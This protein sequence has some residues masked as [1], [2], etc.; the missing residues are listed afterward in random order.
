MNFPRESKHFNLVFHLFQ[1]HL[2][3][4]L[5]TA[6]ELR[7]KGLAEV[8]WRDEEQQSANSDSNSN[9]VQTAIPQVQTVMPGSPTTSTTS[10]GKRKRGR[11][12][13][14]MKFY[15]IVLWLSQ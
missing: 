13:I 12:P 4:L 6:E 7:I 14:G 5:K 10:T 15:F 11:P 3:T 2:A 8:S 1:C 9:G